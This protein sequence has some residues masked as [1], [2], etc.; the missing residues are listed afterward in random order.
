LKQEKPKFYGRISFMKN[1]TN[2]KLDNLETQDEEANSKISIVPGRR[3][4]EKNPTN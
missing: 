1:S 3:K 4:F 2:F